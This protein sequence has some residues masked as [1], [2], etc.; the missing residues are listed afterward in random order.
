MRR[1]DDESSQPADDRLQRHDGKIARRKG[2]AQ[3]TARHRDP[4]RLTESAAGRQYPVDFRL[5]VAINRNL[6]EMV[7]QGTFR[8]DLY[9]RLNMFSI[10]VPPLRARLE[11]IPLLVDYFISDCVGQA[12]RLVTAAAQQVLDLFQQYSWPGNIRELRNVLKRG[13][14]TGKTEWIRQED[15]PFD[16]AQRLATPLSK[17]ADHDEQLRELS[18]QLF[19]AALKQCHGNRSRAAVLLGLTR[20]K[21]YRLLKLHG[22]DG[23]SSRNGPGESDW[24][25]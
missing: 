18:H 15:L 14:F 8:D 17:L 20:N 13:V 19:V 21:F 1:D 25:Q 22:L 6:E 12:K 3:I 11:D 9:D 24:I 10:W 5:I 23:E 7:R 16:V 2:A 4:Y